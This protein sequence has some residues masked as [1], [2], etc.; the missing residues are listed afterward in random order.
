M[1]HIYKCEIL[2]T[3]E[4]ELPYSDI[5]NGEIN[6]Q[7]SVLKRFMKNFSEKEKYDMRKV[8]N[9]HAI[10]SCEPQFSDNEY[11]NGFNK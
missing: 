1:E 8:E 10:A 7:I 11:C 9:P 5:Y 2:N 6:E 3:E 4:I